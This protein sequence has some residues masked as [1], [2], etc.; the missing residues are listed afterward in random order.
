MLREKQLRHPQI[1]R[2]VAMEPVATQAVAL[3]FT[4]GMDVFT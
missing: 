1:S 4:F 3:E 2:T